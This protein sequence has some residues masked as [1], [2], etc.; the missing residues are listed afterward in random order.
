MHCFTVLMIYNLSVWSKI[1]FKLSVMIYQQMRLILSKTKRCHCPCDQDIAW[2]I[3]S[4]V[5][6]SAQ[7]LS[8]VWPGAIWAQAHHVGTISPWLFDTLRPRWNGHHFADIFKGI[9]L[10]EN[11][12]ILNKILLKYVPK[13]LIYNIAALV[14][15]MAWRRTGAKPLSE[16]ML[17]CSTDAYISLSLSELTHWDRVMHLGISKLTVIGSNNGLLPGRRQAII[18]TNVGILSIGPLGKN[19]SENLVGI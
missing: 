9:F 17:V 6:S 8:K 10:N 14:Q 18:W 5:R 15:M 2:L 16:A 7:L 19:F 11:F 3:Y 12:W 13:G 1:N 4:F